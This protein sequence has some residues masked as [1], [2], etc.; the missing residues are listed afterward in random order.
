MGVLYEPLEEIE[1]EK[2]PYG[3]QSSSIIVDPN[4]FYTTET[5]LSS[6]HGL[7]NSD[8]ECF[9]QCY[10]K[11][12]SCSYCGTG[13]CC[14]KGFKANECEADDGLDLNTAKC[15]EETRCNKC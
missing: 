10:Q 9:Q 14:R 13:K 7:S 2:I 3:S 12:G 4:V 1:L 6:C 8:M 15:V 5:F 11:F